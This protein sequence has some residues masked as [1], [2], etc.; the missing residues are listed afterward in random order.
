MTSLNEISHNKPCI[1]NGHDSIKNTHLVFNW[2][3]KPSKIWLVCRWKSSW[4]STN[5]ASWEI[6][7]TFDIVRITKYIYLQI[8]LANKYNCLTSLSRTLKMAVSASCF[9]SS[10]FSSAC[11]ISSSATIEMRPCHEN[12]PWGGQNTQHHAQNLIYSYSSNR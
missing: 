5:A 2:P 8:S 6:C 1:R 12:W 7:S 4:A 10:S 11:R 3:D 9:D